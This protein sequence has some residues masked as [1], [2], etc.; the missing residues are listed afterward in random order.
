MLFQTASLRRPIKETH[1]PRKDITITY[2]C[3]Y[4]YIY[5]HTLI[6]RYSHQFLQQEKELTYTMALQMKNYEN[7]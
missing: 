5:K 6:Y 4:V 7:I 2:M 1:Q 3:I